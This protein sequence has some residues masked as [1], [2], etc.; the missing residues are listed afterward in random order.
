MR[1]LYFSHIYSHSS[2]EEMSL[3]DRRDDDE[4]FQDVD[5]SQKLLLLRFWFQY[6]QSL[7]FI[8]TPWWHMI[9]NIKIVGGGRRVGPRKYKQTL[10]SSREEEKKRGWQWMWDEAYYMDFY[11]HSLRLE[12]LRRSASL[13][14]NTFTFIRVLGKLWEGLRRVNEDSLPWSRPFCMSAAY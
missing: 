13:L 3:M 2:S 8:L 5:L 9:M 1:H 12:G 14:P 6:Q 10:S 7:I 4:R 11:F